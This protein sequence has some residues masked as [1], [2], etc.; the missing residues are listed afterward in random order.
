MSRAAV[1]GGGPM[2]DRL[3]NALAMDGEDDTRVLLLLDPA[4]AMAVQVAADRA[5]QDGIAAMIAILSGPIDSLQR[6]LIMAAIEPL[7]LAAAP[8]TRI[9]LVVADAGSDAEAIVSAARYLVS[10]RAI[11]GQVLSVAAAA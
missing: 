4:D 11:T 2:A 9:A 7:A 10:A 5:R 1:I 8:T 3:R 6:A